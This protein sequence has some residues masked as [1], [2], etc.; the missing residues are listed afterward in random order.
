MSLKVAVE[1]SKPMPFQEISFL[2]F[3]PAALWIRCD[4]HI[5][6]PVSVPA[7]RLPACCILPNHD[8]HVLTVKSCKPQ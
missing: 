3:V 8:D 6:E 5:C 2:N 1:V 4:P 7:P